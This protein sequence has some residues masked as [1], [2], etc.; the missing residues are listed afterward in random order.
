MD[1][2]KSMYSEFDIYVFTKP[3]FFDFIE[4]HP[5]VH[6]VLPYA[7][8]IDNVHFLEGKGNHKGFFDMAFVPHYGTQRYHNYHHNGLDKTQFELV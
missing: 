3:E 6:K 1:N 5:A 7:N 4:D 8:E 2:F